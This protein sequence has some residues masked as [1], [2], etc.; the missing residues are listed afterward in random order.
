MQDRYRAHLVNSLSGFKSANLIST[1]N[2]QGQ[3]N[4]AMISSVIHLGASPALVAFITRPH[5]VSRHTLEN[6][7]QTKQYTINQVSEDFYMAAHQTSAKYLRDE[8]EFKATGLSEFYLDGHLAP[9]VKQSS[10]KYSLTLQEIVPIALNGTQMV[11]GEITDIICDKDAIKSDGYIDIESLNTVA[12]SGL[13]NYHTSTRLSR[14]TYA[15]TD[16]SPQHM[17]INGK[18]ISSLS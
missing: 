2:N 4:L 8:S 9:F 6:I 18:A 15:K 11:I 12:I 14:L 10:L 7:K 17:D 13:D 3:T 5:S 16:H 1:I